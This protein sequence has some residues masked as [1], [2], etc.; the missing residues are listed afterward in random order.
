MNTNAHDVYGALRNT[1]E[2]IAR[3]DKA[4]GNGLTMPVCNFIQNMCEIRLLL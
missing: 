1:R 3:L 4:G 2:Y